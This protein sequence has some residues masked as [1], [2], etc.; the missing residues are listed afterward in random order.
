ME[1]LN[2]ADSQLKKLEEVLD[3]YDHEHNIKVGKNDKNE[4][5]L[6]YNLENFEKLNGD[7]CAEIASS[8]SLLSLS[9]QKEFNRQKAKV[10]W[11]KARINL[12]ISGRL[13]NYKAPFQNFEERKLLAING[14]EYTKKLFQ[15]QTSAE[16]RMNELDG[17]SYKVDLYVETLLQQSKKKNGRL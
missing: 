10:N 2:T 17:L 12:H 5:Y 3:S 4:E 13:E 7:Q 1:E 6:S 15:L 11:C 8:L 9:L 14:D 16:S